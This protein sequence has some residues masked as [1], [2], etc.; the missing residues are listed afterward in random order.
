MAGLIL[1]TQK[2]NRLYLSLSNRFL[3]HISN[4]PEVI[5]EIS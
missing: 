1:D 4:E 3:S 5:D 2:W